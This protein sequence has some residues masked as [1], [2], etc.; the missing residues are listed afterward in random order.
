MAYIIYTSE[1]PYP[2]HVAAHGSRLASSMPT[3]I[4]QRRQR[5][6][7]CSREYNVRRRLSGKVR[8]RGAVSSQNLRA[9]KA[10]V[11]QRLLMM[12]YCLQKVA[13]ARVFLW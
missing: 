9:P 10:K 8:H 7:R 13:H 11:I 1:I 12:G 6:N 5:I 2:I 3:C 4:S